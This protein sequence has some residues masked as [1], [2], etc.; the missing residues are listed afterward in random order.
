V[1]AI[2]G[3]RDGSAPTRARYNCCSPDQC[4]AAVVVERHGGTDWCLARR[5]R[6]GDRLTCLVGQPARGRD[7]N[8]R[9]DRVEGEHHGA[10]RSGVA[11][12]VGVLGRDA[13]RAIAGERDGGA[14]GSAGYNCCAPDRRRA[15]LS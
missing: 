2:A 11:G 1:R 7:C 13:V 9:R 15:A 14:P 4:C 3:E 10:A 5:D 6:A 12:R 8:R